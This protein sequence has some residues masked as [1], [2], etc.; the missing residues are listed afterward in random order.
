MNKFVEAIPFALLLILTPFF[1]FQEPNIAQ[2]IIV[3][4]ISALSGYRYYLLKLE[5]PNY[6]EI[7][8]TELE[9]IRKENRQFRED[10]GKLT[11]DNIRKTGTNTVRF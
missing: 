2:A 8:N 5:Q 4:A 1:F 3:T 6:V 9:T 10:Y 11:L 7:F